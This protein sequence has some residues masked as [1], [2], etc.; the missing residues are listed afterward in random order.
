MVLIDHCTLDK[1]RTHNVINYAIRL[2]LESSQQKPIWEI[3][4]KRKWQ[5]L[6]LYFQFNI[7][8]IYGGVFKSTWPEINLTVLHSQGSK[9]MVEVAS[10]RN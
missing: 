5:L 6:N 4:L 8:S 9:T 10:D 7:V 1:T 2:L 3:S